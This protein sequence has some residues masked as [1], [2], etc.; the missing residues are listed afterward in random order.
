MSDKHKNIEKK[1]TAEKVFGLI[2]GFLALIISLITLL[3]V[4]ITD[5]VDFK[6]ILLLISSL[7][8]V[9]SGFLLSKKAS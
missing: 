7:I 5:S 8:I 4:S 9:V 1:R 6:I 3:V 2:G